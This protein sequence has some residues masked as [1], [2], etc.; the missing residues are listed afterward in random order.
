MLACRRRRAA[1]PPPAMHA[2][3]KPAVA[4]TWYP[5]SPDVLAAAVDG[6]LAAADPPPPL[7]DLVALVAPHAGLMYSGPVAAYAYDQLRGRS[8][9]LIVLVGPS[10]FIGFDGVAVF[11]HGGFDSPLGV[12]EVDEA[13]A[14]AL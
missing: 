1:L 8:P 4:G 10:H 9:K 14:A 12:A 5:D 11:R 7:D 13:A 3:R 2:V 6:Y